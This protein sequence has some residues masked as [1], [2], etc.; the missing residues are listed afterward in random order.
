MDWGL[1]RGELSWRVIEWIRVVMCA[2]NFVA[3]GGRDSEISEFRGWISRFVTSQNAVWMVQRVINTLS[4]TK[5]TN[6]GS[7]KE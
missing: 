3:R 4:R 1:V 5:S 6:F 7:A 2:W